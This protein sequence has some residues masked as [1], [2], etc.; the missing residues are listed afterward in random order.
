MRRYQT[1]ARWDARL[2]QTVGD[3]CRIRHVLSPEEIARKT[4]THTG[5]RQ[6]IQR[7]ESAIPVEWLEPRH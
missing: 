1:W 5:V 6:R 2:A 4:G 3:W 7:L